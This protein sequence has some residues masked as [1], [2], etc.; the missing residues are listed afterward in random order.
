M[1]L[2]L[3]SFGSGEAS[4]CIEV[5]FQGFTMRDQ[6]HRIVRQ[7]GTLLKHRW[8]VDGS[9]EACQVDCV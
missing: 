4:M 7:C 6:L 2:G 9:V 1:P 8:K 3:V 5:V